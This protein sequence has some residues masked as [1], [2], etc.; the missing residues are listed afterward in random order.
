MGLTT[1]SYR[2][3]TDK[4][5]SP[6]AKIEDMYVQGLV[7]LLKMF[8]VFLVFYSLGILAI[9]TVELIEENIM[10]SLTTQI[11]WIS[12]IAVNLTGVISGLLGIRAVS[13][14]SRGSSLTFFSALIL[15]NILY[16]ATQAYFLFF[17]IDNYLKPSFFK[18]IGPEYSGK[19]LTYYFLITSFILIL[20]SVKSYRFHSLLCKIL[21]KKSSNPIPTLPDI[22]E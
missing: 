17:T 21:S 1:V 12:S 8:S 16:L 13:I 6:I 18:S 9:R 3:L 15:Y 14:Q 22:K 5:A 20:M 11:T 7:R 4:E 19:T 2:E 10:S